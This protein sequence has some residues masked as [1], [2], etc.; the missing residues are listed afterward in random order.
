MLD[1]LKEIAPNHDLN[2]LILIVG[3]VL[4]FLI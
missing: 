3:G 1:K 4:V 2:L